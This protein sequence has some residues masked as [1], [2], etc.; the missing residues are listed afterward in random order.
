MVKSV[1]VGL[2][3]N[4]Q[5]A[6]KVI[7]VNSGKWKILTESNQTQLAANRLRSLLS[8]TVTVSSKVN[9]TNSLDI[10]K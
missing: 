3:I 4:R 5:T 10:P 6:K 2:P 9:S 8:R 1:S 7:T